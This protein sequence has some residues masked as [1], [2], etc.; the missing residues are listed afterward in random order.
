MIM[1]KYSELQMKARDFDL[2]CIIN[3]KPVHI[4]TLGAIIPDVLNEIQRITTNIND[5]CGIQP[6][7]N[8]ILNDD[9]IKKY[10]STDDYKFLLELDKE[11]VNK[12]VSRLP[13]FD[14]FDEA[15]PIHIKLF[16]WYFIEMARR[17][18]Y[19]FAHYGSEEDDK[20][21]LVAWP[22]KANQDFVD[23]HK[24]ISFTLEQVDFSKP[25]EIDII[26]FKKSE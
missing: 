8:A 25:K 11:T 22:E 7:T 13:G 1:D 18:F 15:T 2:F 26:S 10:V 3:N 20:F 24:D 21:F 5:V 4:A 17:G 12:N 16:S 19:S 9:L 23:S 14:K 6:Y